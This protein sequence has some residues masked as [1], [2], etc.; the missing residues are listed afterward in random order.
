LIALFDVFNMSR[1]PSILVELRSNAALSA[2]I[3]HNSPI[4]ALDQGT[5]QIKHRSFFL[6]S[7]TCE[8][9][10]KKVKI[11]ERDPAWPLS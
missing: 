3:H 9:E 10:D 4:I 2:V 11:S 5:I 7:L 8:F 6:G 1:V